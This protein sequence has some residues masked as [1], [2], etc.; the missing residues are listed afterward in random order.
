[1]TTMSFPIL[2]ELVD[3]RN[4]ARLFETLKEKPRDIWKKYLCEDMTFTDIVAAWSDLYDYQSYLIHVEAA[5]IPVREA[6]L[7]NIQYVLERVK[8][9]KD[10]DRLIPEGM[11]MADVERLY[12]WI[13][14]ENWIL[15][16]YQ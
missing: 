16:L 15:G 6:V 5:P 14:A 1:M 2:F 7:D 4:L 11:T 9:L 10:T 8:D 12:N 3:V 13:E